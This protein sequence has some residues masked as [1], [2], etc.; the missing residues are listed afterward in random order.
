MRPLLLVL[1]CLL[2]AAPL[3]VPALFGGGDAAT[4]ITQSANLV[5]LRNQKSEGVRQLTTQ[6]LQLTNQVRQL[7]L[8]RR[9][10]RR[11]DLSSLSPPDEEG[12]GR[13]LEEALVLER[14]RRA[15][16]ALREAGPP[17]PGRRLALEQAGARLGR[18][19]LDGLEES[20][21]RLRA[22]QD[23]QERVEGPVQAAQLDNE[24]LAEQ[25]LQQ[26]RLR[27][28]NLYRHQ[29]EIERISLE[30][31][32]EAERIA[33]HRR[34]VRRARQRIEELLPPVRP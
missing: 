29:L 25:V 23:L 22:L 7:E 3:R 21:Q 28:Q 4:E 2:W 15:L 24:I 32:A 16:Q 10:A 9:A 12:F 18:A 11:L 6:L 1:P 26:L 30:E 13:R 5:H 14:S 8:V 34:A 20:R 27:R 33:L 19:A 31:A 17:D